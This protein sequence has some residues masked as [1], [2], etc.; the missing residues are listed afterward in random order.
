[1]NNDK[2]PMENQ[3]LAKSDKQSDNI[4]E[5]CCELCARHGLTLTRHHLIPRSRHNKLRTKRNFSRESMA[6][7]IALLCRPCHSQIHRIFSN[8]ELADDYHSIDRLKEHID[9]INFI[10]W[11]KKRPV[12]LKVRVRQ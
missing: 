9:I 7:D 3:P 4:T 2:D 1:M 8:P 11:V 5:G 12:G 10:Q 6:Q